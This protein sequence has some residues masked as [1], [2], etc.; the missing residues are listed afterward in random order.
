L[1]GLRAAAAMVQS[2]AMTEAPHPAPPRVVT[3][4]EPGLEVGEFRRVL[5]ESGLGATRPV[6]DPERLARMLAAA[7]I[8]MTARLDSAGGPLVGVARGISDGAWACYLAE[9]AVTKAAQGLGVGRV[10]MDAV[11]A[12]VGPEV[13]VVLAS[14]P[15]AVGF[16]ERIGMERIDDAFWFRRAR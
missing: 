14:M 8:V 2:A 1:T 13:A 16:Y 3:A 9:V 10:L 6:D 15:D 12:A 5:V 7:E 4:L 11:R